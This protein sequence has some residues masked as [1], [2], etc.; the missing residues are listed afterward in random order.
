[1]IIRHLEVTVV[2][3]VRLRCSVRLACSNKNVTIS[4]WSLLGAKTL[5]TPMWLS[6]TYLLLFAAVHC[7]VVFGL[8]N[9]RKTN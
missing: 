9:E 8:K 3:V 6:A 2:E 7:F 5:V 4:L 1:M